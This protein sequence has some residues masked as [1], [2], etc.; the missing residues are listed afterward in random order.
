MA[1]H[2]SGV[3]LEVV[4]WNFD[5]PVKHTFK[6][7]FALFPHEI[8]AWWGSDSDEKVIETKVFQLWTT[9][10]P[11]FYLAKSEAELVQQKR[12]AQSLIQ[13][14]KKKPTDTWFKGELQKNLTA[15]QKDA[16]LAADAALESQAQQALRVLEGTADEVPLEPNVAQALEEAVPERETPAPSPETT[17]LI[18][19][20]AEKIDGQHATGI[21][22][23]TIPHDAEYL[24]AP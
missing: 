16:S 4:V 10:L 1:C 9:A 8:G 23:D 21:A 15:M 13:E 17:R 7:A 3:P 11:T 24:A 6:T 22:E 19:A 18:E 14:W 2:V 12:E 5:L 20:S